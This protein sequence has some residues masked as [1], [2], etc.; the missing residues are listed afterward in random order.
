MK[1]PDAIACV[2]TVHHEQRNSVNPVQTSRTKGTQHE[3]TLSS[4][5]PLSPGLDFNL[6]VFPVFRLQ[7]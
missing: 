2:A 7:Q 6:C 5:C 3:I 4:A 1:Q